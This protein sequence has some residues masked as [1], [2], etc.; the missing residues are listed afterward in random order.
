MDNLNQLKD[1]IKLANTHLSECEKICNKIKRLLKFK[2]IKKNDVDIYIDNWDNC[3][4]IS[5]CLSE[6]N[7]EEALDIMEANGYITAKDFGFES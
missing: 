6:M 4:S 5:Y 1:N 2:G 3:I 7:I